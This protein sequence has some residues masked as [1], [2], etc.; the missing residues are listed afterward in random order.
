MVW[1]YHDD[2][3]VGPD[4]KVTLAVGGLHASGPLR[5]THYRID[6]DHSNSYAAWLK[7]GSPIAPDDKTYATLEKAGKLSSVD[8]PTT[9]TAEGG[10][11]TLTFSL[12]RQGVSLL[13]LDST[14]SGTAELI[15]K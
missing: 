13:V 4:A 7:M 5:V 10:S 1:H 2:D 15:Q 8:E 14:N 3:V 12:P 6:Q 11:A 9:V